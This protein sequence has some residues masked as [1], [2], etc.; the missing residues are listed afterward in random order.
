MLFVVGELEADLRA[1]GSFELLERHFHVECAE[2]AGARRRKDDVAGGFDR[3]HLH[4]LLVTKGDG[5][6]KPHLE[7]AGGGKLGA[8]DIHRMLADVGGGVV[9]DFPGVFWPH[10]GDAFHHQVHQGSVGRVF[11][12]VSVHQGHCPVPQVWDDHIRVHGLSVDHKAFK[13][14]R[15]RPGVSARRDPGG[16]AVPPDMPRRPG[17]D[18]ICAVILSLRRKRDER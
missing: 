7:G 2:G 4:G 5:Q 11:F 10:L 8:G 14:P 13:A 1:K 16:S 12:L 6:G 15:G 3:K 9:V 17:V 18:P